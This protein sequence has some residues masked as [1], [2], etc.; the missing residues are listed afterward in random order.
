MTVTNIARELLHEGLIA[1]RPSGLAGQAGKA[2][3]G[4]SV[5]R[6]QIDLQL[7]AD[8]QHMVGVQI[9]IGLFHVGL[10]DMRGNLTAWSAHPFDVAGSAE[11][12][13]D[14]IASAVRA[15]LDASHV[16]P[17]GV[18]VGASGL[19]DVATGLNVIAPS[20]GWVEVPLGERLAQQLGLPVTI[21]NNV[22][23]M[24][25]AET[26][27]G[28]GAEDESMIFVFGR[29]GLA[30]GIVMQRQ[31]VRG[32]SAGAG[33]IG[34]MLVQLDGG[35]PCRC[36]QRGCL[37]T[38]VNEP[39]FQRYLNEGGEPFAYD[40]MAYYL[41]IALVNLVNVINP[42]RIV[43]GGLY[44]EAADQ[45]L[46]LLRTMVQDRCFGGLGRDVQIEATMLGET[47]GVVGAATPPMVAAFYE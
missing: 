29:I 36:G 1:E 11:V 7:V 15:V 44:A 47:V 38:L 3:G 35:L 22:R 40:R 2:N 32:R 20:L 39:A 46:P 17:L 12:T 45:L 6:P 34:H 41:G 10:V 25:L 37:E 43:L 30:A 8:A 33:E 5:G 28:R 16:V 31:L 23:S 42:D 26:Y 14:A 21:E 13:I 18:G 4:R 19:V 24:A 9:G 27:F